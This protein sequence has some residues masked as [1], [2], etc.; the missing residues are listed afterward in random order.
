MTGMVPPAET[1]SDRLVLAADII[2]RHRRWQPGQRICWA[3]AGRECP[4]VTWADQV[5]AEAVAEL[6]ADRALSAR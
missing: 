6:L 4:D 1:A 3:C 5:V 2:H